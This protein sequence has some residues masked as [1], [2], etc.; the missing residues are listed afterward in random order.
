M[1]NLVKKIQS[2]AHQYALWQKNSKIILG[3]SGG[4]DSVCLL[5]IFAK[6]AKTY[7][8]EL[9]IAHV[10]YGLRGHD[11]ERDEKFAREL[12]KKYEIEIEVLNLTPILS[13][14]RRG[15]MPSENELRDIRY[16]FFEKVRQE[17]KFDLI[18][19]AHNLDD[20]AETFL[21]RVIRGAGLAGLS[22]MKF[23]N[24][25]I[26]RPLLATT[27]K[28]I[29]EYLKKEKLEYR[30]DKTNATNLFLRNKIRNQLIP[31]LEKKFNP[32][33]KQTVF[34]AAAN[35]AEDFSLLENITAKTYK[36]TTTDGLSTKKLLALHPALQRRVLLQAIREKKLNKKD[37][38]MPHIEEILK[39]L[40]STKGKNQIVVFKG[41][42]MTRKG[43]KVT[44]SYN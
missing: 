18:A 6:I 7:S 26:I 29:L 12:A 4:P 14:K 30:T 25:K 21:M 1:K 22:A 28:E 13:S 24:E 10:N 43:D 9:I 38:E 41:L 20:Q 44:I 35:I 23:K 2:T 31:F 39:A 11:S 34:D 3:V 16:A 33:I 42:K 40:N 37:I 17:N 27:R 32:N 5:D 8:L 15:S 36:T 19:V